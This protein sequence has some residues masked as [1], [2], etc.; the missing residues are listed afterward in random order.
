MNPFLAIVAL[1][2][3]HTYYVNPGGSDANDGLTPEKPWKTVAK[4]NATAF[5]PG[6]QILFARGGNWRES[7]KASSSGAAG[8]PIVY[9]AYGDGTAKP[10]FWGSEI[11]NNANFKAGGTCPISSS[12]AAVLANH[13]FLKPDSWSWANNTLTI[14]GADPGMDGR[15]Y[16]ACVRVD[17]VHS[18]GKDHLI[19]RDLKTDESADARDGY[20]FR[21]M[22]SDDV[23]LEDCEAWHAGRHH[24]GTI[25]STH[26]TGLRLRCASAMPN[27]PG[28]ATFYVSYSDASRKGDTHQ[29]IDCTGSNFENP[30]QRSYQIFYN[31]G[32]G[33]GPILIQNMI[34]HGGMLSCGSSAN[35]PVTIKGGSVED[36]TLEVF[37]DHAHVDGLTVKGNGGIDNFSSDGLFENLLILVEP[38]NGGPTGYGSGVLMRESAKRNTVR[39]STILIGDGPCVKVLAANSQTRLAGNILLSKKQ[40]FDGEVMAEQ[41]FTAGNPMLGPDFAPLPGSPVIGA[42]KIESPANDHARHNRPSPASVGAFEP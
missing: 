10:T 23:W 36:A 16:T 21:V 39:F 20:G 25:N 34:S 38:K 29:W 8:K 18:N 9:A 12:V 37:G 35:A 7:L 6:D 33:L 31:H 5:A 1:A 27:C 13:E 17:P 14:T 3:S 41:N 24:F 15:V 32:E 26:F 40:P 22:G 30:G 28:G 11:L 42:A 19:F 2:V 4:V